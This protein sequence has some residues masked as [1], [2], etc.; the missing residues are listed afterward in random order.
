[1]EEI[2][3]PQT[4]L[5]TVVVFAMLF[6]VLG[7]V[8]VF[9]YFSTFARPVTTVILVRHAEKM[10]E[11]NNPDPDLAP[12]GFARAQE[13]ARVFGNAGV[14]TIFATQYKRT[15]QTVK[16]LSDR[17]GVSVTLLDANQTDEL[18][19]RI[20]TSLRGQTIFIAGHNNTVP[21]I[22]STLSGETFPVIPESEYDN[23]YIVTIY[24]FGK[25]KVIKLKYGRES[26]QGV[27][28]GTM[29]PMNK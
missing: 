16:P 18:V 21:A 3:E 12:A 28:T 24:R 14:N 5:R 20:Q 23:L 19:K 1:M 17:T 7:A 26:T 15:Q 10:L 9:A 4:R 2:R 11:P 29:V 8:I 13:I 6:T 25:A 22:A 27:G